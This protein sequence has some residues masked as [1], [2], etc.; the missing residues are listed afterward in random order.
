[1]CV[2]FNANELVLPIPY[3]EQDGVLTSLTMKIVV[4]SPTCMNR[5]Q[6]LMKERLRQK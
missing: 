2:C 1:M 3:P 6:T 5:C 4:F